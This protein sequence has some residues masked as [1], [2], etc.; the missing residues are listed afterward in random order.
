MGAL[1]EAVSG[2]VNEWLAG[3]ADVSEGAVAAAGPGGDGSGST[4]TGQVAATDRAAFAEA[5]QC[6]CVHGWGGPDCSTHCRAACNWHGTICADDVSQTAESAGA[7]S[8][9]QST[10]GEAQCACDDGYEGATCSDVVVPDPE[11]LDAAGD[12]DLLSVT[13]DVFGSSLSTGT[14]VASVGAIVVLGLLASVGAVR[15]VLAIDPIDATTGG[16]A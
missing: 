5:L 14:T 4:A 9:V 8:L 6:R 16:V 1:P 10:S 15:R 13:R 11:G 2:F 7:S 12:E 3:S